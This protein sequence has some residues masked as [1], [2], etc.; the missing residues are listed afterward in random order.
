[1]EVP[2]VGLGYGCYANFLT[3]CSTEFVV[4]FFF[5]LRP[6]ACGSRDAELHVLFYGVAGGVI[7]PGRASG[8]SLS[9]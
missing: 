3:K 6:E 9:S 4:V 7:A 2:P 1:M 5:F 8:A